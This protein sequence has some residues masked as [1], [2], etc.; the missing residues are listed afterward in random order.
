MI[1]IPFFYSKDYADDYVIFAKEN[2][3]LL[4]KNIVDRLFRHNNLMVDTVHPNAK[5]DKIVVES[6][7]RI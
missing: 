4:V 3:C 5:G 1:D 6:F 2:G 7:Y